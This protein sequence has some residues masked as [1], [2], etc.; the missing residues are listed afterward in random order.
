M[1]AIWSGALSF[2]LVNIPIKLYSASEDRELKFHMLHKDDLSPIRFARICV[3]EGKEIPYEDIV[4]GYEYTEGDY[5]VLADED[6]QKANLRKT[7]AIDIFDFADEKEID[8]KYYDSP[9]YL[10]PAKGAEKPYSLLRA[11]L[12]KSK[13]VG[14]GKFVLRQKEILCIIKAENNLII[15][16][17]L[18]FEEQI[19]KPEGLKIPEEVELQKKEIDL[20]LRLIDELSGPFKPQDYKDTY[21]EELKE[22]IE[23]KSKGKQVLVKGEEPIPTRASDLMEILRNSLEKQKGKRTKHEA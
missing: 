11:A 3:K 16:N 6:F 22:V 23:N 17:R 8:S 10:E 19:R 7:K 12:N 21:T 5:V 18:R 4:K 1:R 9:Y 15:L 13:K 2:G 14:I 20:A